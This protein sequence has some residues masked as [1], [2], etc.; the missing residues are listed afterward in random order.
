MVTWWMKHKVQ[1][2]P[3]PARPPTGGDPRRDGSCGSP[4]RPITGRSPSN[5]QSPSFRLHIVGRSMRAAATMMFSGVP[6]SKSNACLMPAVSMPM[7]TTTQIFRVS[8][9]PSIKTPS[10]STVLSGRLRR[11]SSRSR[12]FSAHILDAALLRL[13]VADQDRDG[14]RAG[15]HSLGHIENMRRAE[16]VFLPAN[17]PFTHIRSSSWCVRGKA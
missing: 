8:Q 15:I 14:V 9:T 17:V 11:I 13:G 4:L 1:V 3:L 2:A 7:A 10:Q 16:G 12:L 5:E 6:C